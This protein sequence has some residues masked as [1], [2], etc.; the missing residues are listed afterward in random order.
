M[1]RGRPN[2]WRGSLSLPFSVGQVTP[3]AN[4]TL[5]VNYGCNGS[6]RT[7]VLDER[8]LSPVSDNPETPQFIGIP[9]LPPRD[10]NGQYIINRS[11]AKSG[12]SIFV[13]QWGTLPPNGDAA[14][15]LLLLEYKA[16]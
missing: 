15:P 2:Q 12:N 14:E 1:E 5:L 11:T 13:L 3:A 6:G 8:S 9:A 7:I 4:G 10:G 16:D